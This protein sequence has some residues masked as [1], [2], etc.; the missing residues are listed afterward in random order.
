MGI[1]GLSRVFALLQR[2]LNIDALE[3]RFAVFYFAESEFLIKGDCGFQA[4]VAFD[5]YL[6][7]AK[8]LRFCYCRAAEF[9]A[10]PQPARAFIDGEFCEFVAVDGVV[11]YFLKRADSGDFSVE[12]GAEYESAVPDYICFGVVESFYVGFLDFEIFG[13]PVLVESYEIVFIFGAE[14]DYFNFL[15][16]MNTK[17]VVFSCVARIFFA[18]N[19]KR[20]VFQRRLRSFG[21]AFVGVGG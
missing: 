12:Q 4:G 1:V 9:F 11:F 2:Q 10:K 15:I 19:K 13:N 18:E 21:F 3:N 7:F 8:R 6:L 20:R 17:M 5:V 14:I 16:H